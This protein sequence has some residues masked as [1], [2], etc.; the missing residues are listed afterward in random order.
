M[1][2]ENKNTCRYFSFLVD[3]SAESKV[4]RRESEISKA[5]HLELIFYRLLKV[6]IF[7]FNG[8]MSFTTDKIGHVTHSVLKFSVGLP[9]VHFSFKQ[10]IEK[11]FAKH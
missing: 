6:L 10:E 2:Q 1:N 7:I 3:I 11:N 4:S 5:V 9:S 8:R